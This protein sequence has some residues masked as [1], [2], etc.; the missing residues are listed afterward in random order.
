MPNINYFFLKRCKKNYERRILFVTVCHHTERVDFL[1]KFIIW[2]NAER[3]L[4]SNHLK[5]SFW[6]FFLLFL[7]FVLILFLQLIISA[8]IDYI[9][10]TVLLTY[11]VRQWTH[12]IKN[13]EGSH[14]F[15]MFILDLME[16]FIK[17]CLLSWYFNMTWPI[18]KEKKMPWSCSVHY[19][20][21][22]DCTS[23]YIFRP[24]SIYFPPY[25]LYFPFLA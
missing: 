3:N 25:S 21:C 18:K 17:H 6:F 13:F 12:S 11:F 9:C 23:K 8:W 1:H 22:F 4:M 2:R 20:E 16:T 14:F 10:P 15:Y 5:V 19:S 7:I 24:A